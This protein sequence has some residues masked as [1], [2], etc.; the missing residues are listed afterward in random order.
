MRDDAR[1]DLPVDSLVEE[2]EY[3]RYYKTS[4]GFSGKNVELFLG[5]LRKPAGTGSE[6]AH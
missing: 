4:R 6:W 5:K 2:T 3:K 1:V